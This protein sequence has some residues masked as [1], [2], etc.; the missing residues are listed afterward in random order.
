MT[1]QELRAHLEALEKN[2]EIIAAAVKGLEESVLRYKPA[3]NKWSI[4]EI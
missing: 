2:P 3:P 4:L 1:E